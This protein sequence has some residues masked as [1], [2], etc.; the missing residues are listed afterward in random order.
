MEVDF[1]V[2]SLQTAVRLT[3]QIVGQLL[4][5]IQGGYLEHFLQIALRRTV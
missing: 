5:T 3:A 1:S 2:Q 4:V